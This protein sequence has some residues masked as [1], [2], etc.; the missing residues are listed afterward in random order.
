ML[1]IGS[2]EGSKWPQKVDV[3]VYTVGRRLGKTFML[4]VQEQIAGAGT[5]V[6]TEQSLCVSDVFS[7][8]VYFNPLKSIS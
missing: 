4:C 3:C 2:L 5:T 6:I 1:L 8:S 7:N